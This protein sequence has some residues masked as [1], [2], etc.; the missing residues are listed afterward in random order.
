L[1]AAPSLRERLPRRREVFLL[2]GGGLTLLLPAALNHFE[3]RYLLPSVP[4]IVSG[5]V[6]ALYDLAGLRHRRTLTPPPR[7]EDR[8]HRPLAVGSG[9]D[10]P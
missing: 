1:A 7:A 2:V 10:S 8:A 9:P 3:V 5:G 4:L 6:L